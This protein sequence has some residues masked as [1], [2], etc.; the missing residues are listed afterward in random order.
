MKTRILL[1]CCLL[2]IVSTNCLIAQTYTI[3]GSVTDQSENPLPGANILV[4]GSY[5]GT[6]SDL[7][8]HFTLEVPSS[9]SILIITYIGY[10]TEEVS[11]K[12]KDPELKIVLEENVSSLEEVVVV[13]Y[14]VSRKSCVTGAITKI[15][16]LSGKVAGISVT[17]AKTTE[18]VLLGKSSS[19]ETITEPAKN[20]SGLYASGL[21]TAGELNDFSKW[22]M[23][24]DISGQDFNQYSLNWKMKPEQRYTVQLTNPEQ[25]PLIDAEVFLSDIDGRIVWR[26]RTDN[27]GKAEL[28]YNAFDGNL[29]SDK[30][31]ATIMYN[32][33]SYSIG[34]VSEFHKKINKFTIDEKFFFTQQVDIAF[35]VDATS[36]MSDEIEY[37][38]SELND[39]AERVKDTVKHASINLGTVFYRD[40]G[41]EYLTKLSDFSS[42]NKTTID[43]IKS[44]MALGGGDFPEAVDEALTV[45]VDSM[46]WHSN[47]LCRIIFLVLD[48]PPHEYPEVK[49]RMQKLVQ[50]AAL[51]GIRIVPITCSGIDKSTE[52]LMRSIAL[53]TNGTY[54]FLT[55]DSGIGNEHIKPTTDEYTVE[56]L[57]NLLIRLVY[58]YTQIPEEQ[59][60]VEN[61]TS[62]DSFV[63]TV[64]VFKST[65]N[66]N[67]EPEKISWK[68][69]PNPTRDIV[70]IESETEIDYVYLCDISG[71]ILEQ[72]YANSNS[73][74]LN[75]SGFP[76]G[77]YFIKYE[78]EP[79]KWL[80]GKVLLVH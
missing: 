43:F 17:K 73:F 11:V 20:Q 67:Q 57:N 41:D 74:S 76:T 25:M 72:H 46:S 24:Q 53:L 71:K 36:S 16:A 55:N 50:T 26:S 59:A 79:D 49:I 44:N 62:E 52:F 10:N 31:F 12:A 27:T 2:A 34:K 68:Y 37:L 5:L 58:Q 8:G 22:K 78:Y 70:N 4:K 45:A 54:V 38:K 75:L 3:Q 64:E 28:W 56:T 39:I 69:F 48:A 19:I 30:L 6:V 14:G 1:F 18:S 47:A 23:W 61:I 15:D 60:V 21:L 35:V 80:S 9:D 13:G 7:N 77:I 40:N 51:K 42:D 65:E 32:N 29:N 63:D 66:Q 33:K